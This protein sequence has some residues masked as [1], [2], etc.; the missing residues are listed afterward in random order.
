M[1]DQQTP[2]YEVT[3]ATGICS[4]VLLGRRWRTLGSIPFDCR[5][6]PLRRPC[7]RV[8]L[9]ISARTSTR[10]GARATGVVGQAR[11]LSGAYRELVPIWRDYDTAGVLR[12]RLQAQAGG[13]YDGDLSSLQSDLL[14]TWPRRVSASRLE[15]YA[16]CPSVLHCCGA[17]LGK[18]GAARTASTQASLA[19]FMVLEQLYRAQRIRQI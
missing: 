8:R 19:P 15:S 2:F 4:A 13:E 18:S 7:Q 11:L 14:R 6:R 5:T 10:P 3:R 17:G 16:T 1:S 9:R 12:Q